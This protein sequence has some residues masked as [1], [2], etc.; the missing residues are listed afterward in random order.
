MLC[1]C[2]VCFVKECRPGICMGKLIKWDVPIVNV[3]K[4]L[5]VGLLKNALNVRFIKNKD[6]ILSMIIVPVKLA[7]DCN[8]KVMKSKIHLLNL[9]W[10]VELLPHRVIYIHVLSVKTNRYGW[11]WDIIPSVKAVRLLELMNLNSA[12]F[13]KNGIICILLFQI[14]L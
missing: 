9:H 12:S 11:I 4:L 6:F 5:N 2:N 1:L 8:C 10:E 3:Q 7:L 13:V 14:K